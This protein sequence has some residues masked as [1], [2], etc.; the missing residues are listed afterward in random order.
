MESG[1][2][3]TELDIGFDFPSMQGAVEKPEFN[4]AFGKI[5]VQVDTMVAAQFPEAAR[6]FHDCQAKPDL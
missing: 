3:K 4:S 2:R 6:K 1:Y 5:A